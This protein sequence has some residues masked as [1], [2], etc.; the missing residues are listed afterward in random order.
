MGAGSIA[1]VWTYFISTQTNKFCGF[2]ISL[3]H[4]QFVLSFSLCQC[5]QTGI[6]CIFL[7]YILFFEEHLAY[8]ICQKNWH[9]F[10]IYFNLM[11]NR[12]I[13]EGNRK[14]Q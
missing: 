6:F 5:C 12:K 11:E 10:G 8:E 13:P 2:C 9:I 7:A 1:R 14:F 4:F 3:S